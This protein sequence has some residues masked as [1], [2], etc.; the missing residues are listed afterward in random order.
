MAS[1]N[2]LR[3]DI[4]ILDSPSDRIFMNNMGTLPTT[5]HN[6]FES[7]KKIQNKLTSVSNKI[8]NLWLKIAYPL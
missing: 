1:D 2:I 3:S 8:R 5:E 7:S 4:S 6:L